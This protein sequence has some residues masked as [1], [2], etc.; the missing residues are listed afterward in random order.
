MLGMCSGILGGW[1][2][3]LMSPIAFLQRPARWVHL[4]A[5]YPR[6]FSAAPNFAFELAAA[7]TSDDDMAGYDLGNVLY[8]LS[9]AER[10]NPTTLRRFST[11]FARFNL[12]EA[13]MRPAYGLAEA[14]LFVAT[15][16]P[17]RPQEVVTF[18]PEKLAAGHAERSKTG[19]ALISYGALASPLVRIV[20]SETRIE[21]PAGVVGEIWV[22]GENVSAGYWFRPAETAKTFAATRQ[23]VGGNTRT[24]LAENRRPRFHLRRRAVH[25][26]PCQGPADRPRA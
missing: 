10:V 8:I 3:V 15:R 2:T 1:P 26:R 13:I 23:P 21:V 24:G 5:S 9:G 7:R 6:T 14:T 16:G 11:R 25:R 18:E 19:T 22:H 12:P 17:E 20:D 4:M